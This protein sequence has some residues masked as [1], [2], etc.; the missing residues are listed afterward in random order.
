[1]N[2]AIATGNKPLRAEN[3]ANTWERDKNQKKS[4]ENL[5]SH[6]SVIEKDFGILF[7]QS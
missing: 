2:I 4:I 1:M 3:Q 5:Y 7:T 6:E